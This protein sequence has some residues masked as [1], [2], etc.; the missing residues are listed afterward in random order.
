MLCK[1][2]SDYVNGKL[3]ETF[4]IGQDGWVNCTL[5]SKT[6]TA[7]D[8]H[9]NNAR[10]IIPKRAAE[11]HFPAIREKQRLPIA[12]RDS[13]G[14]EWRFTYVCWRN[15]MTVMYV[16]EGLN[17][18]MLINQWRAGDK[19]AFHRIVSEGKLQI[20][21]IKAASSDP[22]ALAK[23]VSTIRTLS[24]DQASLSN[25]GSEGSH[26]TQNDTPPWSLVFNMDIPDEERVTHQ[27][28]DQHETSLNPTASTRSRRSGGRNL[29]VEGVEGSKS[30]Y[31]N[32]GDF[33]RQHREN[34]IHI[35]SKINDP[36]VSKRLGPLPQPRPAT[37]LGKK[38]QVPEE[39]EG[40]G[41][42]ESKEKPH[43][44]DQT[45]LL[46]RS[47]GNLW[48]KAPET[49]CLHFADDLYTIRQ[50]PNESLCKYAGRFNHEYSHCA[51]ADDKTALKAFT[52]GLRDCFFKYMINAN[53]W[54]T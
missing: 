38:Q 37:N 14:R 20:R 17:G 39:H 34:P 24:F 11:A 50:K 54:K 8:T 16:L 28:V 7:T 25:M 48:N 22:P 6:I 47:D 15:G 44:L 33:L 12:M 19:V 4:H 52:V 27:Y 41:D 36:R 1:S 23:L 13:T 49:E 18:Y 5:C 2:S 46:P 51:E 9:P 35:S 30:V 10:L 43:T 31:H 26:N 42:S 3:C 21:T 29:F 53:T 45:S 40:I 32:C